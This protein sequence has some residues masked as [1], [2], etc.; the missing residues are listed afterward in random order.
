MLPTSPRQRK[1]GKQ[2][3]DSRT[4]TEINKDR[5]RHWARGIRPVSDPVSATISLCDF[6]QVISPPWAAISSWV[7]KLWSVTHGDSIDSRSE[8]SFGALRS[9][10]LSNFGFVIKHQLKNKRPSSP[11]APTMAFYP[12]LRA[13]PGGVTGAIGMKRALL[14]EENGAMLIPCFFPTSRI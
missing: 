9:G 5:R 8:G 12:H 13:R 3:K 10:R 14:R 1:R 4:N 2:I 7:R 6:G 11:M